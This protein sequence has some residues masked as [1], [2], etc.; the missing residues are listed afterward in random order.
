MIL[1]SSVFGDLPKWASTGL[2]LVVESGISL[3]D[4]IILSTNVA[5]SDDDQRASHSITA[6]LRFIVWISYSTMPVALSSPAGARIS[7]K[8]LLLQQNSNSLAL[9]AGLGRTGE[10]LVCHEIGSIPLSSLMLIECHN[11]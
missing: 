9:N 4:S 6:I 8:F 1:D 5:K 3:M 2:I 7:L 10:I 11:H